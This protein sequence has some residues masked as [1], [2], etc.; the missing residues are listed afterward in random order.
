[1]VVSNNVNAQITENIAKIVPVTENLGANVREEYVLKNAKGE[2]LGSHIKVYKDSALV[3]AEVNFK[4]ATGVTI[5]ENGKFVFSY[6][7]EADKNYEYLY[8]VYR[9]E[10]GGLNLVALDF[11]DFLMEHEEGFGIKVV[12]HKIT[13]NIKG[14]EKYLKVTEE[15]LQTVN[16]DEAIKLSVD[17]LSKEIHA[18]VDAEI[19]RST[20]ADEYISG[21][22]AEFSASTVN[23]FSLVNSL[24]NAEIERSVSKDEEIDI[25]IA[26]I[27][28]FNN[29]LNNK[30]DVEIVRSK[31]EDENFRIQ[32]EH[33][34]TDLATEISNRELANASIRGEFAAA[35][36]A[37]G[38]RID[39]E[40]EIR[41][42]SDN[43]L[44][45]RIDDEAE[46]R[47][48]EDALLTTTINGVSERLAAVETDYLKYQDKSD[49]LMAVSG[50]QNTAIEAVNAAATAQSTADEAKS[51]IEGFMAAAEIGGAAIDTL[52]EIQN[53][54]KEDGTAASEMLG[55]IAEN[56][57]AIDAEAERAKLAEKTLEDICR[58]SWKYEKNNM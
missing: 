7:G 46:I 58:D 35:D 2:E 16:I 50:A 20:A 51:K 4:G 28:D 32:I 41:N 37:L 15:G 54:I 8:L 10:N 38:S 57:T 14:D 47:T 55:A 17:T 24:I 56:K 13:I 23:E 36:I 39:T 49:V 3:G 12:D 31:N 30:V 29:T 6:S 21:L 11:E 9:N 45:E 22:T 52:I 25:E 34:T 18:K 53:Y 27:K 19:E 48:A 43:T 42:A 44:S 5:D 1:M 40:A 26:N 33:I